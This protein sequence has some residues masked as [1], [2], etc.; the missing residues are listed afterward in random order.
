MSDGPQHHRVLTLYIRHIETVP[1][2]LIV[3][4][5]Q[6]YYIFNCKGLLFKD[7]GIPSALYN[8]LDI[9]LFFEGNYTRL[10]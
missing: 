4:L 3:T 9:E 7:V 5:Y 6:M 2:N 8:F 10:K 1:I